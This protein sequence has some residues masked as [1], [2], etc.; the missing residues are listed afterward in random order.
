MRAHGVVC[1]ILSAPQQWVV[2]PYGQLTGPLL[3]A[4]CVIEQVSPLCIIIGGE[5]FALL[6]RE[7]VFL[8]DAAR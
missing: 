1:S 5:L 8:E 6:E 7:G 3:T 4:V 2:V